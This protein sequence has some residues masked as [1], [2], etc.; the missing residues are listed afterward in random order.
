M[1]TKWLVAVAILVITL[2]A[3]WSIT[4]KRK[5]QMAAKR[6][7]TEVVQ[8]NKK[9]GSPQSQ[10]GDFEKL[11][12]E[13][14]KFISEGKFLEVKK[15]YKKLI[16]EFPDNPQISKLEQELWDLNMKILFSP[17]KDEYSTIY[18]VQPGDTLSSIAKKF[19]TT[20][21]LIKR[22]NNLISDIIRPGQRLKVLT[23]KVS[24]I[25]DKSQNKLFLKINDEIFKVYPCSTGKFN[26]TPTGKF[27]IVNKLIDPVWFKAGAIVPPESPENIL[28][29]RWLGLDL[30][31]YGIHGTTQPETIGK[32]VTQG[33]I[34][35]YNKDVE[36][37]FDIVPIGT[38]VTI[39]D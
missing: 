19:H 6:E 21:E 20:V 23:A 9:Q 33:C 31:G 36:E 28:G 30:K 15:I 24:I 11:Y 38:E 5:V 1:R 3:I 16:Q 4:S 37:L 34:R 22:S 7:K 29:T 13:A 8:E 32:Q 39:I 12:H 10:T 26:S 17:L 25:V 2:I 14:K 27:K 35:M 18:E